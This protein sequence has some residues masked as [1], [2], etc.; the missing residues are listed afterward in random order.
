MLVY[1]CLVNSEGGHFIKTIS[2]C[3]SFANDIAPDNYIITGGTYDLAVLSPTHELMGLRGEGKAQYI[4]GIAI[5]SSSTIFA[6]DT[7]DGCSHIFTPQE[8]Y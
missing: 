1:V 4:V 3:C 5:N 2:S 8:H 7:F 6:T